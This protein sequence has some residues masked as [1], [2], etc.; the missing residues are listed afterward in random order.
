MN[1]QSIVLLLAVLSIGSMSIASQAFADHHGGSDHMAMP[2][3]ISTDSD[4]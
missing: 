3:D 2:I 4:T 1:V